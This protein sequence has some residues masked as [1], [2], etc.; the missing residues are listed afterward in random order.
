MGAAGGALGPAGLLEGA[1]HLPAP[2]SPSPFCPSARLPAAAYALLEELLEG[3][4]VEGAQALCEAVLEAQLGAAESM[5]DLERAVRR[6]KTIL[7]GN[8]MQP[9]PRFFAAQ[10]RTALRLGEVVVAVAALGSLR[11]RTPQPLVNL[12]EEVL[13]DLLLGA[14]CAASLLVI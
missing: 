4:K 1:L 14:R 11:Q 5:G 13:V 6:I 3:G 12:E 10:L 8:S 2:R 9:G 7:L